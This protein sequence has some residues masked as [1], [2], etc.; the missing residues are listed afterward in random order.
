MMDSAMIGKIS[1]ANLYASEPQRITIRD[2]S[3]LFTGEHQSY[4]VGFS[5]G[6]WSCE[7][8]F[9][10]RRG[11]CSHVMAVERVLKQAGM[12]LA[13]LEPVQV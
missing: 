7:C 11:I 3:I 13:A 6:N 12:V 10:A 1:K 8:D 2:F 4:R 5:D 9:F